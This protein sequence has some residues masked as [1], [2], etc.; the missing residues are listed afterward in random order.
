MDPRFVAKRLHRFAKQHRDSETLIDV[1]SCPVEAGS[2][3]FR[4]GRGRPLLHLGA[5]AVRPYMT[6]RDH[7]R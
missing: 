1:N 5:H 3:T 6:I 2:T 7:P 4:H